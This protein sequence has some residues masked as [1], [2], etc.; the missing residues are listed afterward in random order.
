MYERS[1]LP[2][3]RQWP[4]AM[5]RCWKTSP[6]DSAR[7]VQPPDRGQVKQAVAGS[8]PG[9]GPIRESLGPELPNATGRRRCMGRDQL[10][11]YVAMPKRAMDLPIRPPNQAQP[12]KR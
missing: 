2:D 12:K 8:S 11:N 10:Q 1:L 6:T 9:S 3:G 7:L 4:Y 5:P